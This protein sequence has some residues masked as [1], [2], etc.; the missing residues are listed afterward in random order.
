MWQSGFWDGAVWEAR[1]VIRQAEGEADQ[2]RAMYREAAAAFTHSG[3]ESDAARLQALAVH[4]GDA[5]S[6]HSSA[7]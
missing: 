2:A 7:A 3:N 6:K 5:G 4:A 1:G